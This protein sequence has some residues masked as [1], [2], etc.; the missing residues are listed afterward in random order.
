MRGLVTWHCCSVGREISHR[1]FPAGGCWKDWRE[2]SRYEIDVRC[3]QVV[4]LE[5]IDDA[6]ADLYTPIADMPSVQDAIEVPAVGS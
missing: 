4:A 2:S 6:D 5:V 1:D 3:A